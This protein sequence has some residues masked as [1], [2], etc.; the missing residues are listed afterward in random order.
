MFSFRCSCA[1]IEERA[2]STARLDSHR[3]SPADAAISN[4]E[5]NA[6]ALRRLCHQKA[7]QITYSA[8]LAFSIWTRRCSKPP[9]GQHLLILHQSQA[10]STQS[11]AQ[12]EMP[13]DTRRW[14]GWQAG[15]C[16]LFI[17]SSLILFALVRLDIHKAAVSIHQLTATKYC[18]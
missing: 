11:G 9:P 17:L 4:S 12:P 5:L 13:R 6:S 15:S 2:P 1:S 3:Q 14:A 10:R 18:S 16:W 8:L 7:K